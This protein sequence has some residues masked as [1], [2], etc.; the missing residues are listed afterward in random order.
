MDFEDLKL[1]LFVLTI[2][3]VLK[4]VTVVIVVSWD[5][6]VFLIVFCLSFDVLVE[7]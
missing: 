6:K 5:H 3:L 7:D 4:N 1:D 2:C